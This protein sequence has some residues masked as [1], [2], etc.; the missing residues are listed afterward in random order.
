MPDTTILLLFGV[1]AIGTAMVAWLLYGKDS[2]AV[3]RLRGRPKVTPS[4]PSTPA[5]GWRELVSR[6]GRFVPSSAK[7]TPALKKRLV[8][9]GWRNPR[10]IQVFQGARVVT[11]SAL[12]AAA[13]ILGFSFQLPLPRLI[14]VACAGAVAG[15]I[16]PN[17]VVLMRIQP[18][19][20]GDRQ[21][22]APCP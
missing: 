13:V 19:T 15:H 6:A 10:A 17:R 8:S 22:T 9:A 21:R 16:L 11:I 5:L 1:T 2:Q 18:A 14:L 12:A 7:D 4:M 20:E 3:E